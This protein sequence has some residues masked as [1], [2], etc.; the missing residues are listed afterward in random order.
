MTKF[1]VICGPELKSNDMQ[2]VRLINRAVAE[3]G[4]SENDEFLLPEAQLGPRGVRSLVAR[5]IKN[6]KPAIVVTRYEHALNAFA[7]A[8]ADGV[9][10]RNDLLVLLAQYDEA[11]LDGGVMHVTEHRMTEDNECLGDNWPFGVLF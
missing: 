10:N 9:L 7:G 11:A 3:S 8:V 5:I 1:I 2:L 4:A 6:N